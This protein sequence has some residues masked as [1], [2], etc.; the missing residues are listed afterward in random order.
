MA[1]VIESFQRFDLEAGI[2]RHF[3]LLSCF[4]G[5][6]VAAAC[7]LHAAFAPND[8]HDFRCA[9]VECQ[10]RRKNHA[11]GFPGAVGKNDGVRYA[12]AVEV[13]VGFFY[14]AYL[15]EL[16]GHGKWKVESG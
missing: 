6:P 8:F 1:D 14:D 12:F 15:V 7:L 4:V 16:C 13:D 11:D 3:E 5:L 2:A 10:V 9:G